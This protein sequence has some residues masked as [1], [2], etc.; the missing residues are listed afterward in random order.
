MTEPSRDPSSFRDPSGFVYR[1]PELGLLRQVHTSYQRHYQRLMESGLYDQLVSDAMLV[2]H[3]E[4]ELAAGAS[5]DAWRVLR[6]IELPLISY[7]YEWC[8]SACRHA[9]LATLSTQ[10]KA[11]ERDMT[12]KDASAFNIQFR[13][14]WPI[15][16]DTLSFEVYQEGQPWGAYNQFCRHFLAPLALMSKVDV[17]LNR[18]LA[19]HLDGVPLDLAARLLP[20]RCRLSPGMLL[21]IYLHARMVRRYAATDREAH[22]QSA[23]MPKTKLLAMLDSLEHLIRSLR[24]RP[25]GTEWAEYYQATSYS[26]TAFA[27]KQDCVRRMTAAVQAKVTWD[28]GAN[29]GVFSQ[30]ASEHSDVTV[31]WDMD[32]ACIEKG[33]LALRE[34]RATNIHPLVLD[35]TNPTS[36]LGWAGAERMSLADRGPADLILALALI[37][38]LAIANNVPLGDVAK[39]MGDLGR[40]LIIEFVPKSDPQVQRLLRSRE[41]IF[42]HYTQHDFEAAFQRYFAIEDQQVVHTA[43]QANRDAPAPRV[44]Y[45]MRRLTG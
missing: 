12:L 31:A 23:H 27:E 14:V 19:I 4:V 10:R 18:L 37:H 22:T 1:H 6:P 16:I 32:P 45:R 29:T 35:L 34:Q 15:F 3:E 5:K 11:L 41:D 25:A 9:A 26:D 17:S 13:G 20:S 40:H 33:Y 44:I 43:D 8:F 36:R 24:Y 2:P 7:P 21:H 38:H 28:L 42:D 30:I 39:F